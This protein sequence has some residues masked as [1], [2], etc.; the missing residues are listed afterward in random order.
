MQFGGNNMDSK[1]QNGLYLILNSIT[2]HCVV[3]DP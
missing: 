1:G 2:P 3:L